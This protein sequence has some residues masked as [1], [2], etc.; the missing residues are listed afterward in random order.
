[1]SPAPLTFSLSLSRSL[2]RSLSLSLSL[3]HAYRH[4]NSFHSALHSLRQL[5]PTSF[6]MR[7]ESRPA[8][9]TYFFTFH[10]YHMFIWAH[11]EV[12]TP[13]RQ[14]QDITFSHLSLLFCL[15][16]TDKLLGSLCLVFLSLRLV[17]SC[18]DQHQHISVRS[19]PVFT[20]VTV[21][22]SGRWSGVQPPVGGVLQSPLT[23]R[24]SGTTPV[25][26][27]LVLLSFCPCLRINT[28]GQRSQRWTDGRL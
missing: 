10:S 24:A 9:N 11:K 1:M 13:R 21:D 26:T 8:R 19:R 15:V 2:S 3:T 23:F 22:V 12:C 7:E 20:F 17:S 16:S 5:C 4:I 18:T 28:K 6:S 27:V 25:Q 14:S